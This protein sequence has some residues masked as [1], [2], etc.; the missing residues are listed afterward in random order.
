M[1]PPAPHKPRGDI[2]IEV[3]T[4]IVRCWPHDNRSAP[5][6][7]RPMMTLDQPRPVSLPF[8]RFGTDAQPERSVTI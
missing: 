4:T 5:R 8:V 6:N 7:E 1:R 2:T 3:Y